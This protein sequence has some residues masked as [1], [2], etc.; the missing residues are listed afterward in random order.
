MHENG[1]HF[2]VGAVSYLNT[3]PL[4]WGMLHGPQRDS[5]DLSFALPSVCAQQVEQGTVEIGLV[6]VAE[7][8]R[9]GLE[10]VPGVGITCRGAVRSIL[11]VS[12][13]PWGHVR[14]LAADLGSRTS[15]ELARVVLRERFGVQPRISFEKPVLHKMLSQADAALIIGDP[16]LRIN[17]ETLPFD[18]LDLGAEWLR[19]TGLPMVFAAWAGKPGIPIQSLRGITEGSYQFGKSRIDEIIQ[20]QCSQRD[21]PNE[22]GNRYLREHIRF[23]LDADELR[24]L[25]TFFELA[26]LSPQIATAARI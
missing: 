21:I 15:V 1:P 13:T 9:Q 10:I 19:L 4:I 12:R 11:L 26:N 20:G 22:L 23:E 18:F 25:N 5:V 17:P 2:R 8:A 6:P 24:G 14:S 16:A 3:V 7:I